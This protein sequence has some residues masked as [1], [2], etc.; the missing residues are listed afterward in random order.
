VN[1]ITYRNRR[2]ARIENESVR[3][4]VTAEGGHVAEIL[5]KAS[6]VNPL[7]TPPWPSIEPSTYRRAT[8]PEYG[9]SDEAHVLS[10]LMG[11][12]ICLDTF[13]GPSPEE[14]AAGIPVHGEGSVAA[15][16]LAGDKASI[17]LKTTLPHAQLQFSRQIWLSG[18]GSVIHF[19]ETVENISACDRP[20]AWTQHVTLGPPFIEPGK[21][22]LRAPATRSKVNDADLT[23]GRGKQKPGAEFQGFL[24]PRR[25]GGV[26][27]LRTFPGDAVSGGFTTHLMDPAREHAYFVT[28]SPSS[29]LV[30]GYVWK[31]ADFPWMC[32]WEENHLRVD[33]PW[34]G[35]T[36][37]L[38][39]EF[40]VS[41]T[42]ESRRDM[43]TR[44]S[45]FGTPAYRWL[46][47]KTK[48]SVEYC[49]FTGV[50]DSI[51]ET[52]EWDGRES[53]VLL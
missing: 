6:G 2:A 13:G 35:Q 14:F 25:D 53:V 30:F 24:C 32:R 39:I 4:T 11:H 16:S 40:G 37:T 51:P 44:G 22:Q 38:G 27:D 1:E 50:A 45:L 19:A 34:N 36:I 8:H 49:A 3:V 10:G 42:V 15:Y 47:A 23:G 12:N 9:L 41:P 46:P 7:W 52:V 31:R 48:L 18:D 17:S 43:A 26:I 20:I 21:S 5:H 33:P 29:K 28:W